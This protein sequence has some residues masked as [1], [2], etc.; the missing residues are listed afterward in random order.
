M[1]IIEFLDEAGAS[2]LSF[3]FL[4]EC[5]RGASKCRGGTEVRFGTGALD[6]S[7]LIG[8]PRRVG[9]IVWVPLQDFERAQVAAKK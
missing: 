1:N 4:P 9:V 6:P 2:R 3:Q 8:K 7:D 5:I